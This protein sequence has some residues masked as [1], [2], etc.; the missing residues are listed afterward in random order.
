MTDIPIHDHEYQEFVEKSWRLLNL[1]ADTMLKLQL[2]RTEMWKVVTAAMAAGAAFA[3]AFT[4]FG[5]LLTH[6]LR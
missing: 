2:E 6:A 1:Q 5:V 4:A 3:T